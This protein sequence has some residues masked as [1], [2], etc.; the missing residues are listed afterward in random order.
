MIRSIHHLAIRVRDFDRM[1]AFYQE[2]FGFEIVGEEFK[3][4][5]VETAATG[6]VPRLVMM[7]AGNC[8]LEIIQC[9]ASGPNSNESHN[10]G[11]YVH[12]SVEVTEIEKEYAR[13][14][15][16]G[17]V[18]RHP[19]PIDF[20]LVKSVTGRDPEGN[21]IEIQQSAVEYDCNLEQLRAP[22]SMEVA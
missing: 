6:N 16:L 3:P 1:L 5:G 11:A 12:F 2:A 4:V 19:A 22:Q 10:A 21:G 15:G 13:L 20:G 8:F 17:V 7:R 14:K 9:N 18:F